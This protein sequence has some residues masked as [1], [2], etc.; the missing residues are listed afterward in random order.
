MLTASFVAGKLDTIAG[1]RV[2][3]ENGDL[4][5]A[6]FN[7]A[8]SICADPRNPQSYWVG[9]RTSIRY[10]DG[11]TITLLAGGKETGD[12]DGTSENARFWWVEGMACTQ[13]GDKLFVTDNLNN[14]IR[15]VD[16]KT[17]EVKTVAG[18][19]TNESTDGIGLNAGIAYPRKVVFYRSPTAKPDS[20]LYFTSAGGMRRFDVETGAE[21]TLELTLNIPG[22]HGIDCTPTGRLIVSCIGTHSIYLVDP[23][24]GDVEL[25]AGS[26]EWKVTGSADGSGRTARFNWPSDL[27]L[28]DEAQCIYVTEYEHHRIRRVSLPSRLFASRTGIVS[29]SPALTEPSSGLVPT[30]SHSLVAAVQASTK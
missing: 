6:A 20:V 28:D 12:E 3:F 17:G 29:P 21:T 9:D 30:V 19:G 8:H 2:G 15:M 4:K 24:S 7:H 25:L 27:K 14:R 22:P 1:D 13:N 16:T 5:L 26:G 11:K 18:N 23:S 10:C